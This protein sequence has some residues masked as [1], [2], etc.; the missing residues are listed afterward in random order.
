MI[1][2]HTRL[3][4]AHAA[5]DTPELVDLYTEAADT[6]ATQNA[7]GFYLTQAHIYALELGHSDAAALRIR[8]VDIGSEN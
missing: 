4:A 8:L 2:L 7:T 5:Y 1:S 3:L 6:A